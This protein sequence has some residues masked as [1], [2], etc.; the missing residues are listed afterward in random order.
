[1]SGKE[2]KNN[3]L[4]RE[5]VNMDGNNESDASKI[6]KSLFL[7]VINTMTGSIEGATLTLLFSSLHGLSL[8]EILT[9]SAIGG[10][11]GFLVAWVFNSSDPEINLQG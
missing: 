7:G 9:R 2:R 10:V 11:S 1:M 6:E 8:D 5:P 3:Y 4:E